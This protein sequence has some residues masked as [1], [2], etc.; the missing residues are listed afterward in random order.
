MESEKCAGEQA[1]K[2]TT[3]K[4]DVEVVAVAVVAAAVAFV[5]A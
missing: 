1:G 3:W 2:V 5:L 4:T